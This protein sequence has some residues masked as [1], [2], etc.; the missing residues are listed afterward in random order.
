[1]HCAYFLG[2]VFPCS[3]GVVFWWLG[4]RSKLSALNAARKAAGQPGLDKNDP[5]IYAMENKSGWRIDGGRWKEICSVVGCL[6]VIR[7]IVS[8]SLKTYMQHHHNS[9]EDR[10]SINFFKK[11]MLEWASNITLTYKQAEIKKQ[12]YACLECLS[13]SKVRSI[14]WLKALEVRTYYLTELY[15]PFHR[16]HF[17]DMSEHGSGE[18]GEETK[19]RSDDDTESDEEVRKGVKFDP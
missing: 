3:V 18:E 9:K 16:F 4:Y 6:M 13:E 7:G 8:N 10:Q 11:W 19:N 15:E 2:F 5:C 12:L 1:M 14:D 17:P